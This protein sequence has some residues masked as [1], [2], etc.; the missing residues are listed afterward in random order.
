MYDVIIVGG[1]ASG[2]MCAMAAPKNKKILIVDKNATPAKKLMVTGNGKCNLTNVTTTSSRYNTNIDKYLERFGCRDALTFFNNIGL[3]TRVDEQG[4]VYPYSNN[5]R[6]VISVIEK[7]LYKNNVEFLGNTSVEKIEKVAQSWHVM[8]TDGD[9]LTKSLVLAIGT[10]IKSEYI[11]MTTL[12]PSLCALKTKQSTKRLSGIRLSDVIVTAR[13]NKQTMSDRGELLFKDNGLSGIV[14]FN[15]SS[16]FARNKMYAGQVIVDLMPDYS[17]DQI[18][19]MIESRKVGNDFDNVFDGWFCDEVKKLILDNAKCIDARLSAKSLA[20]VIKNLTFDVV[21][22]Y[23]NSQ[24]IS[25]G[26]PLSDLD[27]NLQSKTYPNLYVVGE[28][29]D[30]DGE[31]G[32]Y[33]LQWA[34]TSGYIVGTSV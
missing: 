13:C 12:C 34:W 11:K 3:V 28:L 20:C 8:T 32:G 24:V 31:C 5:A 30:V 1:G 7:K 21:G 9:F 6:S 14:V 4:R 10:N 26:V 25:G 2:C 17:R 16:L 19:S 15:I 23:E 29:C 33:N 27:D 18:V 22:Y